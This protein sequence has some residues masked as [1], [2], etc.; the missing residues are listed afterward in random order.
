MYGNSSSGRVAGVSI[1]GVLQIIF[2]VLKLT[3]L[4]NW[5]WLWVL[6]P[7]W[8]SLGL[9][10]IVLLVVFIALLISEAKE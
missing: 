10:V 2:L 9:F 4:I 3:G 5:S 1:S 7:T 6:A 8:I